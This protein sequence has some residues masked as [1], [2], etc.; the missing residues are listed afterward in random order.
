M[1]LGN[2]GGIFTGKYLDLQVAGT[3][4]FSV[5]ASAATAIGTTAPAAG[6]MLDVQGRAQVDLT[7]TQTTFAVC[8]TTNG[9]TTDQELVDCNTP[10]ADYMEMYP[11]SSD[12]EEGEI[13]V[14][15]S[16]SFVLDAANNKVPTII[17][18]TRP[19]Q[20]G[21]IGITS[22]ASQ[23]GDFNSIGYNLNAGDNPKPLA[24]SGRVLLKVST[25]NGPIRVGDRITSSDI[26]GV[27]MKAVAAGMTVGTALEEL[28]ET[29]SG[30]FQRIM[31]FVGPQYWAPEVASTQP[32]ASASWQNGTFHGVFAM[33]ID[34]FESMLNITFSNGLIRTV[35]GMF[36]T[37]EVKKGVTTIDEDT[38]LPYCIKVKAG[39]LTSVPGECGAATPTPSPTPTS[40]QDTT[41]TATPTPD[42][43][44]PVASGSG[45]QLMTPEPVPI[46][47]EP[48]TP[49]ATAP[50]PATTP[51]TTP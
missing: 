1:N 24:L 2:S 22:I 33:I 17:R 12:I 18:A 51:V 34:T 41:P 5:L 35:K 10:V 44:A 3:S 26:A 13:A 7:G 19:Y 20:D 11:T 23:A 25:K 14:P 43:L 32:I 40:V 49:D 45:V 37:V 30:S 31:V 36:D 38:G 50:I 42:A 9:Q 39:Q 47:T 27:G 4:R 21:I 28:P 6:M 15:S 48:V 8:H 46:P 16:T 29:A